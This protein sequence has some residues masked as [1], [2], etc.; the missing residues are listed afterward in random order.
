GGVADCVA[1]IKGL[2][3][4]AVDSAGEPA[5]GIVLIGGDLMTQTVGLSSKTA[6]DIKEPA[7][8]V[9]IAILESDEI[10]GAAVSEVAFREIRISG[11]EEAARGVASVASLFADLI[12]IANKTVG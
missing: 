8:S 10:A 3:A 7:G 2:L 6:I 11:A 5:I 4:C 12:G 1:K 9:L